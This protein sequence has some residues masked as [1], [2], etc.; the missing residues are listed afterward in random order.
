[1]E[2][3]NPKNRTYKSYKTYLFRVGGAAV[4]AAELLLA[5][6]SHNTVNYG[7]GVMLE[8]TINPETF[9]FG[10]SFRYGKILT[11]CV[12]ENAELE[13][14]GAGSGKGDAKGG[15]TGADSTGKVKFRIGNQIT[16]YY[17]DALKAGAKTDDLQKYTE[18]KKAAETA[19]K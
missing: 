13:M 4:F 5:G 15:T 17:V 8:T 16:G 18:N 2:K 7:D 1:M 14:E 12:R 3:C 6:C 19:A 11:A 10:V 9:A